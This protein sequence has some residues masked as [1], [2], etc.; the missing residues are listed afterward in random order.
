M[1]I[2][3]RLPAENTW[4]RSNFLPPTA[5]AGLAP[6][7]RESAGKGKQRGITKQGSR[8]LRSILGSFEK[9]VSHMEASSF[10]N[11]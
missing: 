6:G 10:V 1:K 11:S 5:Y 7:I 8:L 3:S 9:L 2:C 4:P